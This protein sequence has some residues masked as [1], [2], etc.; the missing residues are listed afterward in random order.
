MGISLVVKRTLVIDVRFV[1]GDIFKIIWSSGLTGRGGDLLSHKDDSYHRCE[2]CRG[3]D[4]LII[5]STGMTAR[6]MH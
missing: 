4:S 2:S 3:G 6:G 1:L 5:W